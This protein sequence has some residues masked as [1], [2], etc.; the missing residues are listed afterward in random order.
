[1]NRRTTGVIAGMLICTALLVAFLP[2]NSIAKE[3]KVTFYPTYDFNDWK[4]SGEISA[5]VAKTLY[6]KP[7]G[8]NLELVDK[9]GHAGNGQSSLK[10]NNCADLNQA[11]SGGWYAADM[12]SIRQESGLSVVCFAFSKLKNVETFTEDAFGEISPDWFDHLPIT[13]LG[14]PGG[15]TN[16][17]GARRMEKE[18]AKLMRNKHFLKDILT[19]VKKTDGSI[20]GRI[21]G[22]TRTYQKI[23]CWDNISLTPVAKGDFTGEGIA[24]YLVNVSRYVEPGPGECG[25]GSAASLGMHSLRLLKRVEKNGRIEVIWH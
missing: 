21:V 16:N 22:T 9:A 20:S 7:W 12:P 2:A 19:D 24:D 11:Q 18:R 1:M 23:K 13:L 3:N 5:H 10:V 17:D 25:G 4:M 15:I 6:A 8:F 14:T